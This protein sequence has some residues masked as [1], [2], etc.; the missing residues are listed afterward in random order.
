MKGLLPTF[1]IHDSGVPL[2]I[3]SEIHQ[4]WGILKNHGL[5]KTAANRNQNFKRENFRDAVGAVVENQVVRCPIDLR[6]CESIHIAPRSDDKR[7]GRTPKL[8]TRALSSAWRWVGGIYYGVSF[9]R[10]FHNRFPAEN[11]HPFVT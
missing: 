4:G 8:D 2:T 9:F 6:R 11:N 3:N 7:V 5:H 1:D 10:V